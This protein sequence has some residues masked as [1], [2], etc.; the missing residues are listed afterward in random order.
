MEDGG[1]EAAF[2]FLAAH[3]YE[4]ADRTASHNTSNSNS[5][6]SAAA[7]GGGG[8]EEEEEEL[9]SLDSSDDDDDDQNGAGAAATAATAAAA[10]SKGGGGGASNAGFGKLFG[11]PQATAGT[12]NVGNLLNPGKVLTD[13]VKQMVAAVNNQS[14]AEALGL[15]WGLTSWE[16]MEEL[17]RGSVL[18]DPDLVLRSAQDIQHG[19]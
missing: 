6:R 1:F 14:K 19:K 18:G 13:A 10:A 3:L 2:S 9:S 12:G 15:P 5:S 17:M 16:L 4:L 8:G 11:A 7:A